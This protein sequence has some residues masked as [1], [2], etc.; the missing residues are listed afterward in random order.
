MS[1]ITLRQDIIDELDF[2]PSI[3]S[4]NI[5]VAVSDGVVTLTGHVRSYAEKVAAERVV[6]RVKGVRGLAQEI[7]VRYPDEKKSADDEIAKR[8]LK[9]MTWDMTIPSDKI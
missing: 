1:D 3:D 9:I 6:Q 4:A 7:E 5:G 2:D 8:A